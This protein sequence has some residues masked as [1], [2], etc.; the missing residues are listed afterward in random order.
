ML[1]EKPQGGFLPAL[2]G[3]SWGAASWLYPGS[4]WRN[5]G[6]CNISRGGC[7]RTQTRVWLRLPRIRHAANPGLPGFLRY[8]QTVLSPNARVSAIT[9]PPFRPT[10]KPPLLGRGQ[11]RRRSL[12]AMGRQKAFVPCSVVLVLFVLLC[13]DASAFSLSGTTNHGT[14]GWV[15]KQGTWLDLG[16]S[17]S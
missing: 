11:W 7:N 12:T 14:T 9:R 15:R 4:T 1:V 16:L 3:T 10:F 13:E 8:D 5:T 17:R 2:P 6:T